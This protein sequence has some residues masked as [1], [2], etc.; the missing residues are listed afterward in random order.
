MPWLIRKHLLV[1]VF[2]SPT[3]M[4]RLSKLS[5][6]SFQK[7]SYQGPPWNPLLSYTKFLIF[8][9]L[10]T[11]NKFISLNFL[12]FGIFLFYSNIFQKTDILNLK[13]KCIF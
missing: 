1:F 7:T 4:Q 3:K 13:P 10:V 12:F 8:K 9:S 5:R 6:Q 11:K 2:L